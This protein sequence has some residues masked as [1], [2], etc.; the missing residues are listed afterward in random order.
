MCYLAPVPDIA[1]D[2]QS[3][4]R[5]L[6]LLPRDQHVAL[7]VRHSVRPTASEANPQSAH[8]T[9]DGIRL[10][11]DLGGLLGKRRKPGRVRTSPVVRC[12]ET[13]LA[14]ARG[15]AWTAEPSVDWRLNYPGP[16][17]ADVGAAWRTVRGEGLHETVAKQLATPEPPPGM[18]PTAEGV[19][20]V[21]ELLL[22]ERG[23][24]GTVDVLVTHE[25][26]LLLTLN[27]LLEL[28]LDHRTGPA[29]L[30]GLFAWRLP[31]GLAIAWR[32]RVLEVGWPR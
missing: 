25:P 22:E 10:A 9:D 12:A 13:A 31:H 6:D 19:A 11:G 27:H 24:F 1:V 16:F 8:L 7:L 26:N 28:E 18:R 21:V 3:M 14:I 17:A 32:G 20:L 23:G 2:V 15:A 29:F 4:A 30:E 5:S